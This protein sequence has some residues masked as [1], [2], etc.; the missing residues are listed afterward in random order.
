[1]KPVALLMLAS[2]L[3]NVL[4]GAIVGVLIHPAAGIGLAVAISHIA[5]AGLNELQRRQDEQH[6]E[7]TILRRLHEKIEQEDR[8]SDARHI[9]YPHG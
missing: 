4:L 8:E 2:M 9:D 7:D 6:A 1:M 5:G 3:A